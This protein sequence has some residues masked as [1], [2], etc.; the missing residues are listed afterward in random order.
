LCFEPNLA[1]NGGPDGIEQ[2]K[3]LCCQVRDKLYPGGNLL[4]EVGRGQWKPVSELLHNLF[5]SAKISVTPDF[6]GI[7]RVVSMALT[8]VGTGKP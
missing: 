3:R 6:A 5:P 8:E 4:L 7:E 1:L 2:I